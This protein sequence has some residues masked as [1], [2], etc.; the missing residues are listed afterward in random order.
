[1][2]QTN[3]SQPELY[4]T[5]QKIDI[6]PVSLLDTHFTPLFY[7]NDPNDLTILSIGARTSITTDGPQ[8]FERVK[9]QAQQIFEGIHIGSV[10]PVAR[11]KFVGGFAFHHSPTTNSQWKG[12]PGA[13]FHLPKI[14]ITETENQTWVTI[15]GERSSSLSVETAIDS[16]QS[17]SRNTQSSF[18][19]ENIHHNPSKSVWTDQVSDIISRIDKE[20]LQ[21]TVLAQSISADLSGT[22]SLSWTMDKLLQRYPDCYHFAI[23]QENSGV[24]FGATPE[25]L[26]SV[27]DTE[28]TTDALAGTRGR[29]SNE[30]EDDA[31]AEELRTSTKEKHEHDLV[32]QSITDK[33]TQFSSDIITSPKQIRKLQDMQHL[34]TPITATISSDTHILSLVKALHPTPAVGGL[35]PK[36][37]LET[38]R[39]IETF[40]RGWYAAPIGWFN[41]DGDGTFAVGIRSAL[42]NSSTIRLFAGNGI[43]NDSDPTEEWDEIQLKYKPILNTLT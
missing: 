41:Q 4:C 32:V 11:P 3:E 37:A 24:F 2:K 7:W 20:G 29:G 34:Y 18:A 36:K 27:S 26:V 23:R 10:P 6:D 8:R 12:F 19:V 33:L 5:S 40:D 43:V 38:I 17:E 21:K 42:T 30:S 16:I 1:M 25:R 31:L 15:V 35:P 39:T 22:F 14:Q 9:T 28:A 13:A